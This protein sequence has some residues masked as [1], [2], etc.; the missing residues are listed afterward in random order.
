[1]FGIENYLGFIMAAILL[2][3]TP[4]TDSM[5]IITRSISHGRQAGFYS[6]LGIISGILVHT[7]LAALG[8]SIILANSPLAFMIVKYIGASY[9]CYLG[10]KMLMAKQQ[11]LIASHLQEN[12]KP[13]PTKSLD[14]W[15]IYKQGLLTN[16]FNPK[17]ALFFLAFFPQFIDASY[18]YSMLSFIVLGLTFAITGFIWCFCLALLASKFSENLRKNPSIE[19]VLNKISGVVFIGLGIKLL[20]EK[21]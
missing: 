10:V 5:Y 4:G 7:L 6:V 9:L 20:T 2:N 18:A 11:P 15:Q 12:G 3:L 19:V 21:G 16:T 1:M 8:L 13:A 17:V 14:H